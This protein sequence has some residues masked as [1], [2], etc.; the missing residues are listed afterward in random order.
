MA[1]KGRAIVVGAGLAG[2]TAATLA[3]R[4][5]RQVTLLER[6][7]AVGGRAASP[8]LGDA[9]VNQ[10]PHALYCGGAARA[11]LA[12]LGIAF[13]G[14]TPALANARALARGA[15]VPLP[16]GV[17]SLLTSSLLGWRGRLD[18]GAIL[19]RLGP[20]LADEGETLDA[21]LSRRTADE[22]A[23]AL[24]AALARLSTYANAPHLASARAALAQ[25]AVAQ[26]EGVTYV[27]G[28][29][30]SLLR[31]LVAAAEHAGVRIVAGANVTALTRHDPGWE[32]RCENDAFVA[33]DVVLATGPAA[34][35]SL[36][37]AAFDVVPVHAACLDLCLAPLPHATPRFVLGIDRPYYYSVH[38]DAA[39]LADSDTVVL[40]VAK[41]IDPRAPVDAAADL[42]EL[43]ALVDLAH[44]TWR[45]SVRARRF[46][47]RMTVVNALVTPAGRPDVD[48]TGLPGVH[49]AGDWVGP[50][51]MLADAAF[52]SARR[53]ARALLR[54]AAARTKVAT[55]AVHAEPRS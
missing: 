48:A 22:G 23:R 16:L 29:W 28:G 14:K 49:L 15:L 55:T 5:G 47:P 51:G 20:D 50:E 13:T 43:E 45:A 9:T 4:A 40:Q 17:A 32:V 52:A 19:A 33:D 41:Y 10:G 25:L 46:L 54:R 1:E 11:L 24:V 21:F 26:R 34:A 53:A 38:S 30:A 37:G 2:L 42:A 12:E 36:T 44:P 7:S 35:S 18:V 31:G 39:R 3:A 8:E 6:G 27:D